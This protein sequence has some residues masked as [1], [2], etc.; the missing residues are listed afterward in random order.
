[1]Q[2]KLEQLE[3]VIIDAFRGHKEQQRQQQTFLGLIPGEPVDG[4][5]LERDRLEEPLAA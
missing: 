5:K 1:M 4:E 3:A 2:E